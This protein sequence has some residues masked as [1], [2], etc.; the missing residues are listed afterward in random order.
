MIRPEGKFDYL[1]YKRDGDSK[2]DYWVKYAQKTLANP[3][4]TK[5]ECKAAAIGVGS[6]NKELAQKLLEKKVKPPRY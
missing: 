4:A 5:S 1:E 3:K 6:F 2:R